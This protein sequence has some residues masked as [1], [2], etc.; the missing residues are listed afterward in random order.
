[1]PA[2]INRG[3]APAATEEFRSRPSARRLAAAGD[4]PP[5]SRAARAR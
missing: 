4:E 5:L 2:V 1:M 3:I